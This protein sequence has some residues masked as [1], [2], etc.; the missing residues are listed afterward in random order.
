MRSVSIVAWSNIKRRKVQSILVILTMMVSIVLFSTSIGILQNQNDPFE[1]MFEKQQGSQVVLDFDQRHTDLD[2][3]V[4]WW[5]SQDEIVDVITYP[6]MMISDSIVHNGSTKSMGS[7]MITERVNHDYQTDLLTFVE[8]AKKE[9][10]GENEVFIPTG[11]AY[12]WNIELNDQLIISLNGVPVLFNVAGIVVDPQ[13]SATLTSPSRIWVQDSTLKNYYTDVELH[14]SLVSI[15]FHDYSDYETL[16]TRYES[17]FGHPFFGFIYDYDFIA[18]M[19]TFVESIIAMIMLVFS[20]IILIISIIVIVFTI[21][22]GI[23]ADLKQIGIYKTLGF[24][25]KQTTQIYVFQYVVLLFFALPIGLFLSYSL[26]RLIL[27]QLAQSVGLNSISP[28][29]FLIGIVTSIVML[30]LIVLSTILSSRMAINIKPI[31]TIRYSVSEKVNKKTNISLAK[32]KHM[33]VSCMIAVKSI[34]SNLKHS[35]FIFISVAVLSLVFTF[36][37]NMYH[38]ISKMNDNLSMWGFDA[39]EVFVT[40]DSKSEAMDYETFISTFANHSQIS[41]ISL[42]GVMV[43]ASIASQDDI[44]STTALGF[45]YGGVWDDIGLTNIKGSN[46][47]NNDEVSISYLTAEKYKKSVGDQ[48]VLY[49]A[50]IEKT[51]KIT[52]IYQSLNAGGWGFRVKAESVIEIDPNYDLPRYLIKLNDNEDVN[53]FIDEFNALHGDIYT[54]RSVKDSGE[55]NVDQIVVMIG[56][57]SVTLSLIFGVVSVIIIFNFMMMYIFDHHKEFG[58]YK[59][60]G[61]DEKTLRDSLRIKIIFLSCL[62]VIMGIPLALHLTPVLLSLFIN[63]MG[64]ARFPFEVNIVFT[65]FVFPLAVLIQLFSVNIATKKLKSINLRELIVD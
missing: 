46:P 11:Y 24:S 32:L 63:N 36:S 51:M 55:I 19:Y 35:I 1:Q 5:K 6:Y 34:L 20:I 9:Y 65:L 16:M 27:K 62:G 13:Y 3:F 44:S 60:I 49:V 31:E 26:I 10:P 48:I 15:R 43:D 39:S 28:D 64:L 61:M 8:G 2:I 37:F 42:H 7:V 21:T 17:D 54:A 52:G 30:F 45:V 47:L 12:N 53:Y 23:R 58:I 33:N 38:S 25:K 40:T 4:S 56:L 50:G 29:Y 57:V 22:N 41:A 59:A 18:Y 14:Q